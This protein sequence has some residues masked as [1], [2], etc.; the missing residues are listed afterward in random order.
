ML[1]QM[2]EVFRQVQ[3]SVLAVQ[4]V[5]LEHVNRYGIVAGE[6]V[7]ERLV[8]VQAD[9]GEALT[10]PGAVTAGRRRPLRADAGG[11]RLHR[12]PAARQRREIQP[13]TGLRS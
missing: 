6:S 10:C 4:E 12:Q 5:P 2:V 11:V 3:T 13:P 7:G 9:G 1:A 8:K